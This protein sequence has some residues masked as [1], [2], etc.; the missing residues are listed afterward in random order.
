MSSLTS[1]E[2]V[3]RSII[4]L[5]MDVHKDSMTIGVLPA[6]AKAPTCVERLPNDLPALKK[7]LVRVARD[8]E[9]QACYGMS[10]AG[11]VL[12][13]AVREGGYACEVIAPSLVPKR[14]RVQ[15]K[16]D[17]RDAAELARSYRSG[18]LVPVR[19]PSEAEERV[20]DVVRC[21][22]LPARDP[23]VPSLHPQVP[24][25]ARLRVSRRHEPV[26]TASPV[27]PASHNG[28]LTA[29]A[30]GP[31]H[32]SGVPCAAAVQAATPQG[33]RIVCDSDRSRRRA[34]AIVGACSSK[35]RGVIDTG[36]K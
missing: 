12:H 32:P 14:P 3:V 33:T 2:P 23:Q 17:K 30:G 7:W 5:G 27:A 24:S 20:R 13:R 31:A 21:R 26:H 34:T 19:I 4:Y 1:V 10:G 16:Y 35:P 18:D 25:A 15:R 6:L 9:L 11:Y 22:S 29:R 28:C 8:G 36:R